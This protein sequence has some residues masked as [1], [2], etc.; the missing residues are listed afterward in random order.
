MIKIIIRS[1]SVSRPVPRIIM[2]DRI[3]RTVIIL[4]HREADIWGSVC[5]IIKFIIFITHP[6]Y[7]LTQIIIMNRPIYQ[8]F[9]Q[10]P[11]L[12]LRKPAEKQKGH[13]GERHISAALRCGRHSRRPCPSTC[14]PGHPSAYA[15]GPLLRHGNVPWL[16]PPGCPPR[17]R[18]KI[19]TG[20]HG[21]PGSLHVQKVAP[22][23]K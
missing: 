12:T 8:P 3:T 19:E 20:R 22:T 13:K 21:R 11:P 4:G 5:Q 9:R 2:R 6:T 23:Q 14:V 17:L 15:A 1:D 10:F 18:R 7:N 16:A